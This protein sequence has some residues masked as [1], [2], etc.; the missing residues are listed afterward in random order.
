MHRAHCELT[1]RAA[2]EVRANLLIHPAVGMTKPGDVDHYTRVRCYQA[3]LP[4]LPA[5][6]RQALA[7]AARHAHGRPA[8]GGAPRASSA[9]T[10]AAPTSS[11]A[12]TTPA[13]ATTRQG[14]PFYGPY[15]AQELM[16]KHQDELGVEMVPFSRW[17]PTS[18]TSTPTCRRT[19]SRP[20]RARSTSPAP[21]CAAGS[22]RGARA[23][24]VV[25]L[26]R[27]R[28]R[29]AAHPPAALPSRASRCSSPASRAPA[30]RPSP[31]RCW[32]SSW[33][34]AAGR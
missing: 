13:P 15:D 21:S 29:A 33:R 8:R 22:S 31:T 30:S 4:R 11:S 3:L 9:R 7:A 34:P 24:R 32:S 1:L 12:A 18:R 14:K 6:H 16:Q 19:R 25:H 2:K 10:T 23:A 26:P 20:A 17:S 5:A 28:R 27:G